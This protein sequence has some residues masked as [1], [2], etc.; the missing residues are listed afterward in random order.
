LLQKHAKGKIF[1]YSVAFLLLTILLVSRPAA[2]AASNSL[3]WSPDVHLKLPA[4]NTTITFDDWVYMDSFEWDDSNATQVTFNNI[5]MDGETLSSWSVSIENA[6]LTVLH[7]FKFSNKL[8]FR[9]AALNETTSI[10]KVSTAG[11]GKPVDIF[12]NGTK[13]NETSTWTY[14]LNIVTL[15]MT[16]LSA[17]NPQVCFNVEIFLHPSAIDP[18]IALGVGVVVAGGAILAYVYHRKKK[19]RVAGTP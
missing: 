12:C 2:V 9:I 19:T 4:Y 5:K 1:V 18:T 7:L 15:N 17:T 10:T 11:K 6:N 3:K 16:H 13:Q 8:D 14:A